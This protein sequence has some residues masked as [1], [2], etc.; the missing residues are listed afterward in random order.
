MLDFEAVLN[1][2]V[3]TVLYFIY[4]F[5][6]FRRA[7]DYPMFNTLN[8]PAFVHFQFT[9]VTDEIVS[10]FTEIRLQFDKI[11]LWL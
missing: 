11:R 5:V 3:F 9:A 2:F 7:S 4:F 10:V 8:V 1:T 6:L